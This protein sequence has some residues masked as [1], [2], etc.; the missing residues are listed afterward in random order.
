MEF[1]YFS[2]RNAY[3]F[4]ESKPEYKSNWDSIKSV[5]ENITEDELINHFKTNHE[6]N[7]KS[8]SLILNSV[9]KEKLCHS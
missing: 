8:I 1:K 6:G 3:E 4:L 2:H 9:L 7:T 5:I